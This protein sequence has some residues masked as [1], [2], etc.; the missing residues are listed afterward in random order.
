MN[1][2]PINPTIH[3]LQIEL[4]NLR[5]LERE[6]REMANREQTRAERAEA[7]LKPFADYATWREGICADYDRDTDG[8][9]TNRITFGDCRRARRVLEGG[10]G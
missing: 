5:N 2:T 10:K 6:Q 3:A 4:A 1:T 8:L 7:A 9:V